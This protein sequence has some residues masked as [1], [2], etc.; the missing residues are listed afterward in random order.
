MMTCQSEQSK[1]YIL[2]N[3]KLILR[4]EVIDGTVV[5]KDGLIEDIDHGR[6]ALPH[7]LDCEGRYLSAGL[8][9]LHTTIW[10]AT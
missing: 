8:V 3:A 6:T 9:E 10:N 2:T 4:D 7:A 5:V 1:S